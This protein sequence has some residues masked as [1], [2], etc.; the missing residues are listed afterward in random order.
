MR[1]HNFDLMLLSLFL[2]AL[3]HTACALEC[4]RFT[5]LDTTAA[6][7]EDPHKR[8]STLCKLSSCSASQISVG[9]CFKPGE[10][11]VT[12][13]C[14]AYGPSPSNVNTIP[15]WETAKIECKSVDQT[16]GTP[17]TCDG[18]LKNLAKITCNSCQ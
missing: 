9:N 2:I 4:W 5:K 14:Y 8:T 3:T 10:G 18:P 12:K 17:Y 11:P 13:S 1:F 16:E 15:A 6:A 7:C